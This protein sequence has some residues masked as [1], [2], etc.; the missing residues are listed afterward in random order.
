L[1]WGPTRHRLESSAKARATILALGAV[2][3][4]GRATLADHV[5]QQKKGQWDKLSPAQIAGCYVVLLRAAALHGDRP[6]FMKLLGKARARMRELEPELPS[7]SQMLVGAKLR[8]AETLLLALVDAKKLATMGSRVPDL[9]SADCGCDDCARYERRAAKRCT[10]C[11]EPIGHRVWYLGDGA[12]TQRHSACVARV[13][14][15]A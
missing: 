11:R 9:C 6:T 8:D 10:I 3:I 5:A 7:L 2:I 14:S 4:E 15:D 13:V 12:K 1:Q